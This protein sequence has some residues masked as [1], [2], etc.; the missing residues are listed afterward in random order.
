MRMDLDAA[1][2]PNT[3]AAIGGDERIRLGQGRREPLKRHVRA[4]EVA[5]AVLFLASDAS[6]FTTGSLLMVGGGLSA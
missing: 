2:L 6:S 3:A 4:D 5:H 1:A